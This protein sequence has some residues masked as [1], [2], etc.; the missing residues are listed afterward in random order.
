[1]SPT[2]GGLGPS[3]ADSPGGLEAFNRHL[4]NQLN[5]SHEFRAK[6]EA[7]GLDCAERVGRAALQLV[8]IRRLV[9]AD[10]EASFVKCRVHDVTTR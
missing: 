7:N 1:M 6:I 10:L 9:A 3:T 5:K 4:G 2:D 8:N